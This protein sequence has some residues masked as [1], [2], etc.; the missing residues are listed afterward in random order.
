MYLNLPCNAF[1]T[2]LATYTGQNIGAGKMDRVK[3]GLR[4]TLMISVA[5]TVCI[6]VLVMI[7]AGN[8]VTL[9][10]LSDLAAEYCLAHL[11]AVALVNIILGMYVPVFGVFQGA[12]HSLVPTC[13]A[14]GALGMRV[15][16]TYLFRYSPVFGY[17]I[18][19][20]N[21]LFGF[22]MGFIITWSYYLSGRWQKNAEIS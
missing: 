16:T 9:F 5:M 20:W 4:Q 6:S 14:T 11:H 18:I 2:T 22:G 21:G 3:T 10:G 7:F 1:Q 17:T 8:I 15:L 19:W 12:N 13:V